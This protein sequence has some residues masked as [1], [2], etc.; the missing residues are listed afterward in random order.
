[1]DFFIHSFLKCFRY[2]DTVFFI[3][4]GSKRQVSFLH[5]YHH[6]SVTVVVWVYLT[7][8]VDNVDAVTGESTADGYIPAF[9]NSFVHVLLYSHY[10]MRLKCK[11]VGGATPWWPPYLTTLQLVQFFIIAVAVAA[12]MILP[13][14]QYPLWTKWLVA[15]YMAT[16]VALFGQFFIKKYGRATKKKRA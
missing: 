5:V 11:H 16:M 13:S 6:C 12:A 4:K 7:L 1:L 15:G 9:L 2:L 8:M 3:L 10:F 14:C